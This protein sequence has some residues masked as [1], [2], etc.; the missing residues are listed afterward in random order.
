MK[1]GG[2]LFGQTDIVPGKP[3]GVVGISEDSIW[4]LDQSRGSI[5][6]FGE[7]RYTIPSWTRRKD[8]LYPSLV[9]ICASKE[10]TIY[11]TDS[12]EGRVYQL[13]PQRKKVSLINDTLNLIRPT[14]IAV[15]PIKD[16]IWIVETKLHRISIIDR[17]GSL[18]KRV[19]K[20][21]TGVGEF[22]YPTFI[23]FDKEGYAYVVDAMNFRIQIL[24]QSGN[25]V[26]GFG[27][28]GDAS[29]YFSRPKGIALDSYGNIYV[30][31]GLF[32]N[33]QVFDRD[34]NFLS[35][36]GKQGRGEGD[37]WMPVGI[38]IDKND[39]IYIADSYN[40]RIQVFRLKK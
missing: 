4:V 36:F 11:F 23:A 27:Q 7:D 3:V 38:Y 29:G 24:D 9:G 13:D 1:L 2:F 22:N 28:A 37:L 39:Y 5:F 34:G 15:H 14:G 18:I 40:S 17:Y 19:G 10:G 21:G 32:H 33:V 6:H 25:F 30:V 35:Y 20:R 26:S 12:E 16:E 8:T 31:D